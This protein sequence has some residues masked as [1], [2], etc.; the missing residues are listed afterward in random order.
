MRAV[1]LDAPPAMQS[2]IRH[3]AGIAATLSPAA[4]RH[5]QNHGEREPN[6]ARHHFAMLL[7]SLY[8]SSAAWITLELL[9]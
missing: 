9:S 7:V 3:F 5:Q 4:G 2:P 6:R 1:L 8:I